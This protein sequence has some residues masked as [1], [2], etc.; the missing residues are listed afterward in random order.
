M[1]TTRR[2]AVGAVTCSAFA[3]DPIVTGPPK[4]MMDSAEARAGVRPIASSSRRSRLSR[5]M[6]EEW[7]RSAS[8]RLTVDSCM[9]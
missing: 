2:V 8:V 1:P 6:A 5:R 7:S 4:T 3:S 9:C